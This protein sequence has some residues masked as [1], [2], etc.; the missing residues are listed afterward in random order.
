MQPT[1][2]T[3]TLRLD[4]SDTRLLTGGGGHCWHNEDPS[5]HL[6]RSPRPVIMFRLRRVTSCLHRLLHGGTGH[7]DQVLEQLRVCSAEDQVLDMVGKNKA[8]LTVSHVSCAVGMLWQF[9]REKP[10]LLRT[11]ELIRTHPQFLTLRV[12]A[13]NKIAL[14][15]DFILVD[16]LYNFLRYLDTQTPLS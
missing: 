15:D 3:S 9:Q 5:L 8:K 14:M 4:G 11:V 7:R 13:E 1:S 6:T 2:T 16:M 10:Q 12:L